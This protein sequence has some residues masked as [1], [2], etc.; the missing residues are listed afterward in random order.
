VD[1]YDMW[2]GR[3]GHVNSRMLWNCKD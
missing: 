2:R 1:S 3:L